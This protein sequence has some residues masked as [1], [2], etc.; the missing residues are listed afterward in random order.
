VALWPQKY[1]PGA[2]EDVLGQKGAQAVLKQ[3]VTGEPTSVALVGATGVGKSTLA[4]LYAGALLCVGPRQDANPCGTCGNCLDWARGEA[5]GEYFELLPNG[6]HAVA[7][8]RVISESASRWRVSARAV[9]VLED[10]DELR[11]WRLFKGPLEATANDRIFVFTAD[12]RA[13]IPLDIQD[14]LLIVE[15]GR[16]SS[17]DLY[18]AMLRACV[19]E[20]V[21]FDHAALQLIAS[22]ARNFREAIGAAERLARRGFLTKQGVLRGAYLADLAWVEPYLVGLAS[23]DI[24]AQV[25]ALRSSTLGPAATVEALLGLIVWLKTGVGLKPNSVEL[26]AGGAPAARR[27]RAQRRFADAAQSLGVS[28]PD[29][30][31]LVASFWTRAPRP[32]SPAA[33]DVLAV[34]FAAEVTRHAALASSVAD[35]AVTY[36][37][38]ALAPRRAKVAKVPA[39]ADEGPR[40][41]FLSHQQAKELYEAATFALQ[42]Y[43]APFNTQVEIVWSDDVQ[44]APG[45]VSQALDRFAQALQRHVEG[46]GRRPFARL[47]LNE[48]NAA[49]QMV[50]TIIGHVSPGDRETL[51]TWLA[52]RAVKGVVRAVRLP[53]PAQSIEGSVAVH[54]ELVRRLWGGLD[55]NAHVRGQPL[56][57]VLAVPNDQRRVL[58]GGFTQHS[59][60][61]AQCIGK[62]ARGRLAKAG[63]PHLSA[64]ADRAWDWV[65]TGWERIQYEAWTKVSGGRRAEIAFE[66]RGLRSKVD[67]PHPAGGRKVL[68]NQMDIM[69]FVPPPWRL[70]GARAE[71]DG[72]SAAEMGSLF[73]DIW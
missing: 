19:G 51:R 70:E 55:P 72:R 41:G 26:D 9:V 50:T 47:L 37:G 22:G 36:S 73:A 10:V 48:T 43:W 66:I 30:W 28:T 17:S 67:R 40:P 1:R 57:D 6:Q 3:L 2:F 32:E 42:V 35:R 54:W 61:A 34:Q 45:G 63:A 71:D 39:G 8:R 44:L 56:L 31:S 62:G 65:A 69:S 59:F 16:P 24:A 5:P 14:R 33:L 20:A 12:H 49:G 18:A 23:G 60:S 64:I 4:Q 58:G 11:G 21:G 13:Q 15:L 25:Q 29:L 38:E 46:A 52:R 68:E 53:E 27:I 7:L